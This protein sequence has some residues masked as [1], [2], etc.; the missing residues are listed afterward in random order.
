MDLQ[1]S[2]TLSLSLSCKIHQVPL[3]IQP[4][5]L[6]LCRRTQKR[7]IG[8]RRWVL[9]YT[10][11]RTNFFPYLSYA[12]SKSSSYN[13]LMY[14]PSL[15]LILYCTIQ[16]FLLFLLYNPTFRYICIWLCLCICVDFIILDKFLVLIWIYNYM[17]LCGFHLFRWIVSP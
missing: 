16:L 2:D 14:H 7:F 13:A 5:C 6:S 11:H 9:T 3:N 17:C 1:T 4:F 15:L 12:M 8:E 10:H